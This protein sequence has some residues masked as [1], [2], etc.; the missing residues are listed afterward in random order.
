MAKLTLADIY[1]KD[2][3]ARYNRALSTARKAS[4]RLRKS[5][6][7]LYK[8]LESE[9]LILTAESKSLGGYKRASSLSKLSPEQAF[10][11]LKALKARSSGGLRKAIN[12]LGDNI[13]SAAK[14]SAFPDKLVP[15]IQRLSDMER[16]I[17]YARHPDV[18]ELIYIGD[19]SEVDE[20]SFELENFEL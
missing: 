15:Y 12:L 10:N 2:F 13:L 5:N 20:L 1:G 17:F 7:E 4:T 9:D 11:N 8:I 6:P 16:T 18:F 19:E 3:V 14:R